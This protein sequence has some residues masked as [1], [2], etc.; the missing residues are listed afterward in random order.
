MN[1]HPLSE[2]ADF[3]RAAIAAGSVP[4]SEDGQLKP[5]HSQEPTPPEVAVWY[6]GVGK[7]IVGMRQ[8]ATAQSATTKANERWSSR[9]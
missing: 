1:S 2:L 4:V 7:F 5:E 8:S 6:A 9:V 3:E